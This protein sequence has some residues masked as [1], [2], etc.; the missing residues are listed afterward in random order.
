MR[1]YKNKTTIEYSEIKDFYNRRAKKF[2]EES[3]YSATMLQDDNPELVKK[4]NENEVRV[5]KPLLKI[6]KD[7]NILDV[8]C[9]MGRWSDAI[10]EEIAGYCGIDISEELVEIANKR[11]QKKNRAFYCSSSHMLLDC[12]AAHH[13]TEKFNR[14]LFIGSL[15]Y[16]NDEDVLSTFCQV[17]SVCEEKALICIREPIG[18]EERLTLKSFFSEELNDTYNAVYR[19]RDDLYRCIYDAFI[20]KEFHISEEDFMFKDKELNNRKETAQYYFILER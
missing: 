8:A 7:S 20:T 14:V 5:L 18:L 11:N 19:T 3:P 15:M 16:L 4:R 13:K 9:G 1:V 10:T 12:L 17:E 6:G 2:N